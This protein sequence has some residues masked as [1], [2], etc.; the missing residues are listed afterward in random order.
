MIQP[1]LSVAMSVYNGQSHLGLAIESILD[2]TFT[3]FEF[4]ILNDGSTDGSREIIDGYATRDKRI[5][6]IH[7]ENKG[8][9]ISLNQLVNE[10][11]APLIARMD[12]DDICLPE[13]FEKQIAFM[14]ANP[15][16]GVLGTWT[17]DIDEHGDPYK[18]D[19]EDHPTSY[20]DFVSRIGKGSLICHPSVVMRRDI[21]LSVGGYHAA[22]QHCEDFDLW[23]RLANV[24]KLCSL[25]ERLVRYR[26]WANQV[27]NRHAY[28]QQVG[29]IVSLL[30]YKE[31]VAGRVD[32]TETLSALPPMD[33]LDAL[34]GRSGVA[35]EVR[36]RVVPTLI[37]AENALKG[38]G[39][40]MI[41]DFVKKGGTA[42]GLWR[43]AARLMR[44]GE[45][46]RAL[47]LC[48]A[49]VFR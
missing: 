43:T 7:R 32:P 17:A 5:R 10:A 25:P 20:E 4:L 37:Y 39:F 12:A 46:M 42:P 6:A 27:S 24:T 23:L 29:A 2:Q 11:R 14:A 21:V 19:G 31:R 33:G 45:P 48:R 9:V 30:A 22:F 18:V 28:V 49:L 41:V 26:H 44:I 36:A 47:G 3:D 13:R 8:L 15:D 16:H 38:D 35:D 34:F 40:T 1:A